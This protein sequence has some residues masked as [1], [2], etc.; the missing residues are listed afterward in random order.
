[1]AEPAQELKAVDARHFQVEQNDMRE[2]VLGAVPEFSLAEEI[3][4]GF[5]A[6]LDGAELAMV[7]SAEDLLD[8]AQIVPV[9]LHEEKFRTG[10]HA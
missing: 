2:R 6:I 7:S 5:L 10:S 3:L 4:H 8:E 9:I 1:V